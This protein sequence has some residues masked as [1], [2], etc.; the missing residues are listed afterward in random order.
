MAEDDIRARVRDIRKADEELM[1]YQHE[2]LPQA[3][4]LRSHMEKLVAHGRLSPADRIRME[5]QL[6][7]V[8]CD[9][10]AVRRERMEAL[11]RLWAACGAPRGDAL[12]LL[13]ASEKTA[14]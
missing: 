4:E 13:P 11:V 9:Y 2:L 6:M 7:D 5:E 10:L 14:R 12:A 8:Q 3:W 1:R